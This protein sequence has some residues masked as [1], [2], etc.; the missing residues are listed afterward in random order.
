[1]IALEPAVPPEALEAI[2]TPFL[3]KGASGVDVPVM[4]PLALLLDLAGEALRARLFVVQA[5]GIDEACLRPDFTISVVSAH[6]ASGRGQGLYLYEGKAFQVAPA[7]SASAEEFLQVGLE[8]LGE[9]G[10][11][12]AD[13]EA[14]GLAWRAA[15]AGGRKD[16]KVRMG[17][18][19]LFAAFVDGLGLDPVTAARLKR[20]FLRPGKMT[21]ELARAQAADEPSREGDRVAELLAGL[22]EPQAAA[23][24]EE[25]WTL[26]GIEPVGGRSA[27][28]IV[29]RLAE[30]AKSRAAPRL[31]AVQADLITRFR[32]VEGRPDAALGQA[33]ALAREAGVKL[34]GLLAEWAERL[35]VLAGANVPGSALTLGAGFGRPFGYYDGFLFEVRS[36]ALGPDE[37]VAAGGRYDSLLSR[38][39]GAAAS[40]VGA[41]VRPAR[42]WSGAAR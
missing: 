33:A 34:D 29:H 27:A 22:P 26:A 12:S 4:P 20:A 30:R 28:E 25:L 24:L 2:R 39:G 38:M 41:M 31:S 10:P 40:A 23:A 9:P 1:M 36:S 11:R 16:L 42:A 6:L 13:A 19:G 5:D 32:A 15:L 35:K 21:A 8:A 14:L 3:E 17:D 7:G 37:P 18:I